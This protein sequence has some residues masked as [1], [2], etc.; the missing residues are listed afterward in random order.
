VSAACAVCGAEFQPRNSRH[1]TC[2]G[3]CSEKWPHKRF[4]DRWDNDPEYRARCNARR[5]ADKNKRM[6][7]AAYRKQDL[8]KTK[9]RMREKYH[10]DHEYRERVCERVREYRRH[11]AEIVR[12]RDRTSAR[13]KEYANRPEVKAR[14]A[15]L[16]RIWRAKIKALH[17]EKYAVRQAK[18][19]DYL[20]C[21][22]ADPEWRK[23]R[24]ETSASYR[25]KKRR[26]SRRMSQI[27]RDAVAWLEK[28]G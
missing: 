17:P 5:A 16:A 24:N 10:G 8:E 23:V 15:E 4:R 20:R 19:R 18:N 14:R 12:E 13:R 26:A 25:R 27:V 2:S 22:V 3:E 11:H 7:Y 9:T 21:L 6:K 1:R 28:H